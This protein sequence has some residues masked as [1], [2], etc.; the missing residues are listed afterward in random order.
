MKKKFPGNIENSNFQQRNKLID[1]EYNEDPQYYEQTFG[2]KE[3]DDPSR[4]QLPGLP[5][6]YSEDI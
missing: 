3:I 6:E 2:L 1:F 4:I 5:F